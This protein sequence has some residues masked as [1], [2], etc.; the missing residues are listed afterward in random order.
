MDYSTR[1]DLRIAKKKGTVKRYLHY[2]RIGH[3]AEYGMPELWPCA[4]G[5]GSLS[6]ESVGTWIRQRQLESFDTSDNLGESMT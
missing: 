2:G 4:S 3:G 6:A 5:A 1:F